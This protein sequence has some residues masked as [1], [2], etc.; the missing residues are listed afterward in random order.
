MGSQFGGQEDS[1][2]TIRTS[3][4]ADRGCFV[5]GK[6]EDIH[7]SDDEGGKDAQLGSGTQKQALGIGNQRTKVGH[8]AYAQED[9]AGIDAGLHSNIENI[10]KSSLGQYMSVTVIV[11]TVGIEELFVPHLC[12]EQ[13]CTRQISQNHAKGDGEQQQRLIFL[14]DGQVQKHATDAQ[15]HQVLPS[16][17]YK[18]GGESHFAVEVFQG[19]AKVKLTGHHGGGHQ[20]KHCHEAHGSQVCLHIFRPFL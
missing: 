14:L 7:L 10:Q 16:C 11:R 18:E 13:S 20:K 8:G 6:A 1:C 19:L 12:V 9:K 2:R 3:D 17:S 4:D 5:G 15:H